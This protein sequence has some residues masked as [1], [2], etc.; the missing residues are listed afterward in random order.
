MVKG[1]AL[2]QDKQ[3]IYRELKPVGE[4]SYAR[5]FFYSDPTYNFPVILKRARP[6]LDDK[7]IAR[8]KQEFDVL[9]QLHSPYIVD[10]FAYDSERNEYR[11]LRIA[12]A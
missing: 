7:E 1:I 6:E 8:F 3:S 9:K 5:V 2:A 11:P 10:V 12:P 4:G